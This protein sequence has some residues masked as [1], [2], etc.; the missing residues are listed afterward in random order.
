ML[1][2]LTLDKLVNDNTYV[3]FNSIVSTGA[4]EAMVMPLNPLP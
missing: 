4:L 3:L 1:K 2:L